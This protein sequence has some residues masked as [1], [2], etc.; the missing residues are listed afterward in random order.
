M[1]ARILYLAAF[2]GYLF[3]FALPGLR[4]GSGSMNGWDS[5]MILVS[6]LG[7]WNGPLNYAVKVFLNLSNGLTLLVFPLH[8]ATGLRSLRWLQTLAL[9]SASYWIGSAAYGRMQFH[10]FG[11]GFWLW[12]ACLWGMCLCTWAAGK[13]G[14]A[15]PAP[16][17]GREG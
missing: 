17:T 11:A 12:Y 3:S 7:Y 16:G 2:A 8:F 4:M 9:V 6:T 5:A 13:R 14:R 1:T 10:A 15:R